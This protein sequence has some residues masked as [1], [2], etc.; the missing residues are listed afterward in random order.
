MFYASGSPYSFRVTCC[1]LVLCLHYLV[2]LL[3]YSAFGYPFL[4][5]GLNGALVMD[6]IRQGQMGDAKEIVEQQLVVF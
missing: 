4:P 3:T 2:A 5:L 1:L 6:D